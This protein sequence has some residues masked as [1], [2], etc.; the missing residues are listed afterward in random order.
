V[1]NIYN[2]LNPG[3][4][5]G[6]VALV[7]L[8]SLLVSMIVAA[9]ISI[10][11]FG[12]DN[13]TKMISSSVDT[14]N[15]NISFLKFLQLVQSI[16]LFIV[17]SII[18]AFLF[19]ESIT[20]YLKL[21]KQPYQTSII[22][23]VIIVIIASP[24]INFIGEI[25]SKLTLP[26]AFSSI[27]QWMRESEDAAE[28]LTKLF[29][30][31]ETTWGLIFNIFLIGIIPAVGEELLFRG[32]VQRIFSEWT[33]NAHWGIWIAAILF[34]ALH[35]QFYGFVPRAILGAIF[36]YLFVWS[37]NLWLPVLAHFINNTVAVIAYH[38]YGEGI[39][40]VDPDKIGTDSNYHVA[41][42]LSVILMVCLF[43]VFYNYEK[44]KRSEVQA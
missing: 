18:L 7:T 43:W 21:N 4:K 15:E 34:S 42:I 9:V 39:L 41:T 40:A 28:K 19:G 25:N 16:G 12:I 35:F 11:I 17:P 20:G 23:A 1:K 33:K 31:T 10:P 37:G 38:L 22:I 14:G 36:G 5:L 27:E 26:S 13:F 6:I 2:Q 32:I 24:F 29:L 3:S 30:K 44:K 8:F